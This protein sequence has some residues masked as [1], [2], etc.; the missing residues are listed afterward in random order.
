MNISFYLCKH[1]FVLF[2]F[3][4]I[5]ILTAC[6]SGGYTRKG[7]SLT[8][9]C[10]DPDA[11]NT[12]ATGY[13][14]YW[15]AAPTLCADP[16]ANNRGNKLPCTYNYTGTKDNLLISNN[17]AAAH[18]EG[19]TGKGVTVGMVDIAFN[20]ANMDYA[21]LNGKVLTYD[22]A[23]TSYVWKDGTPNLHFQLT[24]ANLA[25]RQTGEFAGGIAP[26]VQ[27]RWFGVCSTSHQNCRFDQSK[28]AHYVQ[29]LLNH[30]DVRLVNASLT[31]NN[32]DFPGYWEPLL[33]YDALLVASAG[34]QSQ[35]QPSVKWQVPVTNTEYYGHFI[36]T[37]ALHAY[38][39]N[40]NVA[41]DVATDD[42]PYKLTRASYSNAC[43]VAKEWCVGA[44]SNNQIP[45]LRNPEVLVNTFGTSMAA[46]VVTGVAALVMEAYPWMSA[47]NVQ[48][49]VLTTATDIGAPG[50]DEI[51]GWGL[52]NA[53]KAIHGPAEF[54]QNRF[55]DGFIA[56]LDGGS[57]P[58]SNDIKGQ[59]WLRKLG[60]GTLTLTG[61]NTYSGGTFVEEGTLRS[62]GS[63]GSSVKVS[64]GATFM[65]AGNGAT[66]NGDYTVHSATSWNAGRPV[67]DRK[68]MAITA[69]Q[70]G[71][72][73]TISGG[74]DIGNDSRLLLLREARG[75]SVKSTETLITTGQGISGRFS[76]V[77]YGSNFF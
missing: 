75:Y 6:S 37:M 47:L 42:M 63:F 4:F 19:F 54:V 52:V 50:V 40:A 9:V 33:E 56:D 68:P 11:N 25:G 7:P 51:Y 12:G 28:S 44:V 1:L 71:A 15:P 46:P 59:G 70:L 43:G 64:A 21:P 18:A 61:K 41:G 8:N 27:F 14:S 53:A 74:A 69:I 23:L 72:P 13:C 24:A 73:L 35:T 38:V 55:I 48:Q 34:N 16:K 76:E 58:F 49:T 67:S 45:A 77:N 5:S 29:T 32:K 30:G 66:I 17:A 3:A 62:S 20:Y 2:A 26:D 39:P 60:N 65:T 57:R 22:T 10:T 36:V 31:G